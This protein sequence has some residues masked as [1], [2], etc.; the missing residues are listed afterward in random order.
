MSPAR[1]E[2]AAPHGPAPIFA[3]LGDETRLGIV[4][5]LAGG[6]SM[7]IT[8]LTEGSGLTRQAITKHLRVLTDAGLLRDARA[9]RERVFTLDPAG[10]DA[11]R[12]RLEQIAAHWDQALGRLA[13]L[14]EG[15]ADEGPG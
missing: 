14:V 4:G 5:R 3:A 11:A 15:D 9:G 2:P 6:G 1:P 10:V 7:S 12:R 13:A 8:R